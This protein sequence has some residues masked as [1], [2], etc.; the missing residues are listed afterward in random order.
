MY[1]CIPKPFNEFCEESKHYPW[2]KGKVCDVPNCSKPACYIQ[3]NIC[4]TK[5]CRKHGVS[6][7]KTCYVRLLKSRHPSETKEIYV[8]DR[9]GVHPCQFDPIEAAIKEFSK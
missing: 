9:C 1:K 6:Y 5:L 3:N 2:L 7:M 4:A 8:S